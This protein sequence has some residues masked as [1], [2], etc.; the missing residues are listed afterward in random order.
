MT[1]TRLL[2]G[3]AVS[4]VVLATLSRA[5]RRIRVRLL[6]KLST[7]EGF[8]A[9]STLLVGL[10][11]LVSEA[12]GVIGWFAPW[13]L[14]LALIAVAALTLIVDHLSRSPQGEPSEPKEREPI[15]TTESSPEPRWL[16]WVA[17]VSIGVVAAMWTWDIPAVYGHGIFD[18]DSLW[19]HLP[20]AADFVQS[21]SLTG[22]HLYSADI[23]ISTYPFGSELMIAVGML[24]AGSDILAPLLNYLWAALFLVAAHVFGRRF[25]RPHLMTLAATVVLAWPVVVIYDPLTAMNEPMGLAFLM[26]ALVFTPLDRDG[27]PS[28]GRSIVAGCALGLAV[29]TK[30]TLLVP[31]LGLV[32]IAAVAVLRRD[33]RRGLPSVLLLVATTSIVGGF[34]YAR[35]LF[36]FGSPIPQAHLAIGRLALPHVEAAEQFGPMFPTLMDQARAG[37]LASVLTDAFGPLWVVVFVVAAAG[38]VAALWQRDTPARGLGLVAVLSLALSLFAPGPVYRGVFMALW[39][40]TRYL[41]PG[42]VLCLVVAAYWSAGSSRRVQ[43]V[44]VLLA[45]AQASTCAAIVA[46]RLGTYFWAQPQVHR[47]MPV[48]IGCVLA[49]LIT[50]LSRRSENRA[51]RPAILRRRVVAG[52]T[53]VSIVALS[54]VQHG[55]LENRYLTTTAQY[56]SEHVDADS[57]FSWFRNYSHLRIA[58]QPYAWND[59]FAQWETGSEPGEKD[60][61][62]VYP[63]YGRALSNRV[64]PI[65]TFDG[66][67]VVRPRSCASFWSVL[68]GFHATHVLL[69]TPGDGP[70]RRPYRAWV[71]KASHAR[72]VARARLGP[73]PSSHLLL[74]SVDSAFPPRC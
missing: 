29:S 22:L 42:L 25:G 15:H 62:F 14:V 55:Y 16:V 49:V 33:R 39:S 18:W 11:A 68:H 70:E 13:P 36:Q 51:R 56:N 40:N 73:E 52:C 17:T 27:T 30:F 60:L 50:L 38:T 45:L 43:V 46:G 61:A 31:A 71:E 20:A 28:S 41:I 19:Y 63:L 12:L 58:V 74:Y 4:G 53:A 23:L 69:W 24:V 6:P 2:L 10:V 9:D 21:H 72:L 3:L 57:V 64:Q 26:I 59:L 32:A 5:V 66:T 47:A 54:C 65:A 48:V 7:L 8:L 1:L 34:W 67:R 44:A 37:G 35:N